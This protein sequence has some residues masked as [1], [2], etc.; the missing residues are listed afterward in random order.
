MVATDPQPERRA[1]RTRRGVGSSG[2]PG[3]PGG[4]QPR[5]LGDGPAPPGS[6]R[7]HHSPGLVPPHRPAAAEHDRRHHSRPARP[8]RR[9]ARDRGG[10]RRAGLRRRVRPRQ[11]A[12]THRGARLAAPGRG[13]G[14]IPASGR[15]PGERGE[16]CP[17][18]ARWQRQSGT[19][20]RRSGIP[21]E[22]AHS[23]EPGAA[24]VEPRPCSG[25]RPR[26]VGAGPALSA[27]RGRP[28]PR[29]PNGR[30]PISNACRPPFPCAGGNSVADACGA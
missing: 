6:R 17:R 25:T 9:S 30:G 23:A 13:A 4:L 20:N 19:R 22:A 16:G 10:S 2:R 15:R 28:G 7:T 3:D 12:H 27:F 18:R 8:A 11:P 1:P 29:A 21:R 24:I 5:C 14:A 26:V